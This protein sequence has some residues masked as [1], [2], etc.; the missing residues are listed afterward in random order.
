MANGQW[1]PQDWPERIRALAEGTL[2]PVVPKRAATVMLLKD[3]AD[4]PAVHMLR[5]RGS[6]AFAAD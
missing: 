6:M 3:T 1:F 4:G 2:T 5:R